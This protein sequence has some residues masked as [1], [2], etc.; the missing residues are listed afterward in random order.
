MAVGGTVE[1][2]AGTV[3]RGF[4]PDFYLRGRRNVRGKKGKGVGVRPSGKELTMVVSLIFLVAL[5]VRWV[6]STSIE[7]G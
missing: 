3:R 5:A 2:S 6:G 4:V 1:G 7:I